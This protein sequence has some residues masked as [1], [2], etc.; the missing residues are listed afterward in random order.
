MIDYIAYIESQKRMREQFGVQLEPLIEARPENPLI[1]VSETGWRHGL[2]GALR[3][4]AG[5]LDPVP[6]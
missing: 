2:A 4:A 1:G 6:A 5:R 3:R